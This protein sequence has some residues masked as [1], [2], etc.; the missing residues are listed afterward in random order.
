ML[1]VA[2]QLSLV[3]LVPGSTRWFSPWLSWPMREAARWAAFYVFHVGGDGSV[4]HP[5]GSG[6]TALNYILCLCI[7]VFA[8]AGTIVWSAIDERR[9]GRRE[10]QTAY[11][12]LR[13][14]MRFT[15][16]AT[17][18]GYGFAKVFPGQFPPPTLGTLME[19]Y[20]ESS[21]M[22]LLWTFMGAS[23][24]YTVFGG[25]AEVVPGLLLFF[26]RTSTPGAMA[27]AAV[28]LNIALMNFCYDVPVKLYSSH[29]LAMSLFLLLPDVG[30]MWRFFVQRRDAVLTGVWVPRWE[31]KTL[32]VAGYCLQ[33]L[34]IFALLYSDGFQNYQYAHQAKTE[35]P[36]IYG[37]WA[38]DA[39][40]GVPAETHWQKF[41][42]QTSDY[43]MA[44]EAGGPR[45]VYS[46]EYAK[47]SQTLKLTGTGRL[48]AKDKQPVALQWAVG[49]DGKLT[50]SGMWNG[51]PAMVS[52][53]RIDPAAGFLLQT[54][55]FHWVQEYPYNR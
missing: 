45:D 14:L 1:P 35:R 17:L 25:L 5:T 4:W 26:R 23:A 34:T 28:M 46:A 21:P 2:G 18:L 3:D 13:L 53:H 15:L 41:V 54:R 16:A 30:P 10:Y 39:T 50:L 49:A 29:L 44:Y 43:V 8:V 6:D 32:R 22:R 38:V 42:A 19:T 40:Q 11:A 47:G 31:R 52:M 36:A 55:E 33:G 51:N 48:A 37:V 7:F 12:W 24:P 9:G 27:S 20:G